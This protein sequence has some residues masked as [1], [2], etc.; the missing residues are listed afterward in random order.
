M[1]KENNIHNSFFGT[2]RSKFFIQ[3]W[4]TQ[5]LPLP[6]QKYT[7][8]KKL[9]SKWAMYWCL[10]CSNIFIYRKLLR[11]TVR[12]WRFLSLISNIGVESLICFDKVIIAAKFLPD[13]IISSWEENQNWR[14]S[15][16]QRRIRE[17]FMRR[18]ILIFGWAIVSQRKYIN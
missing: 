5:K 3:I 17:K 11:Q 6:G 14:W 10:Q 13:D 4:F 2:I 15:S 7:L 18:T 1:R 12:S 16:Q 9:N 8:T